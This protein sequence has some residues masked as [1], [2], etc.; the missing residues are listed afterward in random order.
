LLFN[1]PVFSDFKICA[2]DKIF[3]VNIRLRHKVF[4]RV[5]K[6][7][8]KLTM[9]RVKREKSLLLKKYCFCSKLIL[10]CVLISTCSAVNLCDKKLMSQRN[11]NIID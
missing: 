6:D 8:E 4:Y 10:S 5:T 11:K 1:D 2:G 9:S 7:M 3:H